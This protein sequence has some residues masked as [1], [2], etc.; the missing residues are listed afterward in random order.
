MLYVTQYL[1]IKLW[2]PAGP[3]HNVTVF[4]EEGHHVLQRM[5]VSFLPVL[6]FFLLVRAV[7]QPLFLA[8]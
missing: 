3:A 1:L 7:L 5:A 8:V 6:Q 2:F 4:I